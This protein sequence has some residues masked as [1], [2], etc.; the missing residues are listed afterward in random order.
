M[1]LRMLMNFIGEETF[2]NRIKVT[3]IIIQKHHWRGSQVCRRER[4]IKGGASV[5]GSSPGIF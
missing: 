4:S 3:T 2:L 5:G 1:I